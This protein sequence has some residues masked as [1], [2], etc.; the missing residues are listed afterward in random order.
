MRSSFV[1]NSIHN[2]NSK[3]RFVVIFILSESEKEEKCEPLEIPSH[4]K[5]C[6]KFKY[7]IGDRL[8]KIV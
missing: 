1:V 7:Q 5:I 3:E 8:S 2:S 4:V 6:D